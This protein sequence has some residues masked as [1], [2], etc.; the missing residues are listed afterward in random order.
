MF[1]RDPVGVELSVFDRPM[2]HLVNPLLLKSYAIALRA[3][4]RDTEADFMVARLMEF[5]SPVVDK[6]FSVCSALEK[7]A[8]APFQ[9][10]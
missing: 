9:C 6:F 1:T 7:G 2:H 10:R 8:S 5:H 4:G 3:H